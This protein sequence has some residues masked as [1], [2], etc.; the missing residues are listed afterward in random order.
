VVAGPAAAAE[1]TAGSSVE[2]ATTNPLA[3][4]PLV[5]SECPSG[6]VCFWSGKTFGQK[7]CHTANC[8]SAFA[9]SE[10]GHHNLESIDPQSMFNN[11]AAHYVVFYNGPFGEVEEIYGPGKTDQWSS[12]Y[13]GGFDLR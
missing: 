11:T 2:T 9:G 1:Q 6:Y 8:F 10:V 5:Q 3:L 12:P 13:G 7:E 4:T